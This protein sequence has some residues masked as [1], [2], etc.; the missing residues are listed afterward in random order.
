MKNIGIYVHIPFCK[1]KC[2]YCDF[3]SFED[4]EE[5]F[6]DYFNCIKMEIEEK[7]KE[8]KTEEINGIKQNIGVNTIY[9]GGGTP[10]FVDEKYIEEII[11]TIKAN[12]K[13]LKNAEITI[14]VNPGTVNEE[15]LKTYFN[16]GINRLSIGL[17]S[18]NN[19]LL[20]MLGRIHN[21]EE[22]EKTYNTARKVRI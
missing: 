20:K 16:I 4:K 19:E 18:T 2:Q 14:E 6:K 13:V 10:S 22:F 8:Y 9:I 12:F 15:K 1:R 17:Q 11:K 3:V 7:S 21:Y 5:M